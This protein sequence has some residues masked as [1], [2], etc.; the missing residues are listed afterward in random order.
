M[1]FHYLP[2]THPDHSN[3]FILIRQFLGNFLQRQVLVEYTDKIFLYRLFHRFL[4]ELFHP[5]FNTSIL[6]F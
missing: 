4:Y 6:I 3:V 5:F 1:G 2:Q